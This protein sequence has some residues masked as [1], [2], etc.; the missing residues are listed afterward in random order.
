M[1]WNEPSF[2]LCF[3]CLV[4]KWNH[5]NKF[6]V[7][8]VKA[9]TRTKRRDT[10]YIRTLQARGQQYFCRRPDSKHFRFCRPH[11]HDR[12]YLTPPLW[13][14]SSNGQNVNKKSVSM[15]YWDFQKQVNQKIRG[16]MDL[17]YRLLSVNS[18]S[19]SKIKSRT[20]QIQW[21]WR[22]EDID[23]K[24]LRGRSGRFWWLTRY[25]GRHYRN[26]RLGWL[27]NF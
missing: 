13:Y 23:F 20:W 7:S 4:F 16:R 3:F 21:Q 6:S 5:I 9:R 27:P 12:D 17:V 14:K 10:S 15:F 26:K 11:G 2:L 24:D 19:A 22:C 18:Y 8:K 1:N 25:R